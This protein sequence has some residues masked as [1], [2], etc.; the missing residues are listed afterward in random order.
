MKFTD[1]NATFVILSFQLFSSF[2]MNFCV[3]EINMLNLDQSIEFYQNLGLSLVKSNYESALLITSNEYVQ[4]R[5]TKKQ[6]IPPSSWPVVYFEKSYLSENVFSTNRTDQ[7]ITHLIDPSG[8]SIGIYN[9]QSN[10]TSLL[11]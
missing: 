10:Q 3:I 2:I 4:I 6:V 1:N 11:A 7:G 5:L 9:R 8:N